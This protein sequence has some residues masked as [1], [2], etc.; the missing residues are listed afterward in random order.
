[1]ENKL[2]RAVK[3]LPIIFVLV[4]AISG[5]GKVCIFSSEETSHP[6][7]FYT[8]PIQTE[9]STEAVTSP[10]VTENIPNS[11]SPT[12][13]PEAK[14]PADDD[15]VRVL[16]YIPTIYIDLKYATTDNFTGTVIYDFKDAY[17]RYGTVK[18]LFTVQEELSEQ[19]YSLKIWDAYRPVSAQYKLWQVYPDPTYVANPNTGYSSHSKG[20]TVDVTL[21]FLD[22]SDVK[23]PSAF[24]DFS[25][26]ADRDYSDVSNDAS[27]NASLLEK[28]MERNG[29][30]GYSGEW[31]HY[32]DTT[33]YPIVDS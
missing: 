23:M 11:E 13:T 12:M 1:M 31:W 4:F 14:I 17:L 6:P 16:D 27:E 26:Y 19:G 25:S 28:I 18:K 15:L 30:S 24:D 21:V 10:N 3:S 9:D 8:L 33:D 29:F 2:K 32:S 7:N 20:N 22:G 5:C